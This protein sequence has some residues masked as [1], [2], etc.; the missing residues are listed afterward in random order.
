MRLWLVE[1]MISVAV[2]W[3]VLLPI[4]VVSAAGHWV[5][6]SHEGFQTIQAALD[7]APAG[8]VIDVKSG[9]YTGHLTITKPVT[10]IGI[11]MP[12]LDGQGS[13]NVV[14]IAASNVMIRGFNVIDSGTDLDSSPAG[15]LISNVHNVRIQD[16]RLR[17]VEFGIYLEQSQKC[18]ITHNVISGNQSLPVEDRGDGIRF[19][20]SEDNLVTD[21]QIE[22]VRD[23]M[24]FEFTSHNEVVGNT[25]ENLRYGL[26]YMYSDDNDFRDNLFRNDVAGATPMYSD[27]ITFE[28]NVFMDMTDYRAYGI[29]LQECNDCRIENNLIFKDTVGIYMNES[30]NNTLTHNYLIENGIGIRPDGSSGNNKIYENDFIN[31]ITQ[32]G[33]QTTGLSNE[34]DVEGK[35]NFWT[36]Y[37]GYDP[38]HTGTGVNP[39]QSANYFSTLTSEFPVLLQFADSPAVNALKSAENQFPLSQ[40]AGITDFHPLMKPIPIPVKWSGYFGE[41]SGQWPW[42]TILSVLLGLFGSFFLLQVR[43][44][45]W[46]KGIWFWKLLMLNSPS[47]RK[48]YWKKS[49]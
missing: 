1:I 33:K 41:T 45:N 24:L 19:W 42:T 20:H 38:K 13:G 23:G 4:P 28:D 21:N 34:W 16:C 48:A 26:H 10:L 3:G 44:Q 47:A 17:N 12:V 43:F 22:S 32:V 49:H 25:L 27:Y 15:I 14:T 7:A 9:T 30:F 2:V 18:E 39:Y 29:L 11:R 5:V 36:G 40:V 6:G 8:A 35:G 37:V 31:N 46:R